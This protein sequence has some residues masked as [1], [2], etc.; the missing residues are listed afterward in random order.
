MRRS[1][2][3]LRVARPT[4][5]L[6][7]LGGSPAWQPRGVR[8]LAYTVN[9]S[10][11]TVRWITAS[12]YLAQMR[13][14]AT[15]SAPAKKTDAADDMPPEGASKK[16]DDEDDAPKASVREAFTHMLPHL[17]PKGRWDHRA[18]IIASLSFVFGAKMFF[19]AVP[20]YFKSIID[21]LVDN[22]A[23]KAAG[24]AKVVDT[25]GG[26]VAT[27]AAAEVVAQTATDAAR[28]T[29]LVQLTNDFAVATFGTS[30]FAFVAAYGLVRTLAAFTSEMRTAL[31]A[32]VSADAYTNINENIFLKLHSLDLQ[33]HLSRKTGGVTKVLDRG[34]RAFTSMAWCTMFVVVPT[35]FEMSLVCFL[36]Q[37][38]VGFEFVVISLGAVVVYVA[39]TTTVT[40][41]RAQFRDRYNEEETRTS[42]MV[43][44]SLLNYETVK[45]FGNERF[46]ARRLRAA[47][48]R[49]NQFVVK[50]EQS[51]SGLNFGQ[52]FIFIAA[53]TSSLY[54]ASTGVLAGT[55]T[56]GDLVL[57]DSLLLQL[58]TP[59]SWLGIVYREL[60]TSTQNM[61]AML[62]LLKRPALHADSDDAKPFEF[63]NGTIVLENACYRYG[64]KKVLDDVSLE[65]P[66]GSLVAFVGP[67]GTGKTTIFRLM[68]RFMCLDSG[69]IKI[70]G[71]DVCAV[72]SESLRKHIGVIPQD[73]VMFNDTVGFNIRYGNL[74]ATDDDLKRVALQASVHNSIM[75]FRD[76][77]DAKVG[78]RGLKLSGGE[79]QRV[80]I[81]RVLLRDPDI[82]LADEATSALDT[83]TESRIMKT[84][85]ESAGRKRTVVMIA[86]RLATV[87]N[88]DT[89]FVLDKAGH[90]AERGSHEALLQQKGMYHTLWM[91]QLHEE[92]Q[93]ADTT[94]TAAAPEEVA[95]ADDA[96]VPEGDAE[97]ARGAAGD[98]D[99]KK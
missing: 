81:A 37:Q 24:G 44:D 29:L 58:Y 52:Q 13:Y 90:I 3:A 54:F 41:W 27:D 19:V 40:N 26:D 11:T 65:I 68:F 4:V 77:Y 64:D 14:C 86:H 36:L 10:H 59:L 89:I 66:G 21:K 76:G 85:R 98:D 88:C 75:R 96:A 1:T 15:K 87:K 56:V 6:R 99:V 53:A 78:E 20:F 17:W 50:L 70:D 25:A 83:K 55:M 62:G 60:T 93:P 47:N 49:M 2:L 18:R 34:S 94:P 22:N 16:A 69:T 30:V 80:A 8:S 95:A 72:S 48:E 38:Q 51:M 33:Y 32:R 67:S 31:F 7:A 92:N 74:D 45:Y 46:E 28:D 91:Q 42:G 84:L 79:K 57:V 23:L 63:K 82:I 61:Q 39:W 97:A 43:V 73:T 12:P 35:A 9:H 71:Q 5:G